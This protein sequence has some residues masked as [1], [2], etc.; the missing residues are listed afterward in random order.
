MLWEK[1]KL[2]KHQMLW[3]EVDLIVSFGTSCNLQTIKW[4][5][6]R[7]F[8]IVFGKDTHLLRL[9]LI[10]RCWGRSQGWNANVH[11]NAGSFWDFWSKV[12]ISLTSWKNCKSCPS[13]EDQKVSVKRKSKVTIF[14]LHISTRYSYY[15]VTLVLF[16]L[17]LSFIIGPESDHWLCLSLTHWLPFSKLDWCDP[18]MWRWQLKTCWSCY[19]WWCWWWGSCWQ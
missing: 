7:T 11:F 8:K 14:L 1:S 18:G 3:S 5:R 15:L 2:I 12:H 6:Q 13:Y 19:C 4:F 16:V 10:L 17:F 9:R